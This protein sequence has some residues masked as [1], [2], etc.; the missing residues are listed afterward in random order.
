[1]S[2][3]V[4]PAGPVHALHHTQ[5]GAPAD[6]SEQGTGALANKLARICYA[7][8]RSHQPYDDA[9]ACRAAA[10]LRTA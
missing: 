7:T 9:R 4:H 5:V 2:V 6:Q 3:V 10:Q 8:L 1:M